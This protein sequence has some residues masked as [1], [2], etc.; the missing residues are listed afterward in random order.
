MI[1]R[2]DVQ[3]ARLCR[4][5][6][7]VCMTRSEVDELFADG[8][9]GPL[10][11]DRVRVPRPPGPTW[12]AERLL[13]DD[14]GRLT[15]GDRLMFLIAWELWT[16]GDGRLRDW[17]GAPLFADLFH[18]D[19]DNLGRVAELLAV[20]SDYNHAGADEWLAEI[21]LDWHWQ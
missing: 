5:L 11:G 7:A 18:L 16:H 9:G 21:E 14:G 12:L 3:R 17:R 20:L 19:G 15:S 1:V 2:D 13:D 8:V 4:A 6:L 10:I